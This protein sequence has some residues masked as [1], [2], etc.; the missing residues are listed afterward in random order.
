MLV[1]DVALESPRLCPGAE[2]GF[3]GCHEN[4][5][6]VPIDFW[7]HASWRPDTGLCVL[8]GLGMRRSEGVGVFPCS[9]VMERLLDDEF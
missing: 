2:A 8:S 9:F 7:T 5:G 6:P 3:C 1:S 4:R